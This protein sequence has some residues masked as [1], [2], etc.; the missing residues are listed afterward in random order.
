MIEWVKLQNILTKM[1]SLKIT[2]SIRKRYIHTK[3]KG[4]FRHNFYQRR[5]G[6]KKTLIQNTLGSYNEI[7]QN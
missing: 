1:C 6:R 5:I 3:Q 2:L 7:D 4:D